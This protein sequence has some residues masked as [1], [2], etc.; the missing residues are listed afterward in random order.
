MMATL[1]KDKKI[2]ERIQKKVKLAMKKL[3]TQAGAMSSDP[4]SEHRIFFVA[5][6]NAHASKF[7][8]TGLNLHVLNTV[9]EAKR[10]VS[11]A[12]MGFSE[13]YYSLYKNYFESKAT[14][15][16]TIKTAYYALRGLKSQA[17]QV[18]L[19]DTWKSYLIVDGT[20]NTITYDVINPMG[21]PGKV[22]SLKKATVMQINKQTTSDITGKVK[23]EGENKVTVEFTKAEVVDLEWTSHLIAFEFEG[24]S[25]GQVLINKT[26]EVKAKI[27]EELG[28]SVS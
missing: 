18:F 23:V 21:G 26:F 9:I 22:K 1:Q 13:E 17:D 15:A 28:V 20:A 11:L 8:L 4:Y 10:G 6:K 3:I 7:D 5:P 27:V 19:K 12:D 25:G 14:S 24:A 16:H 2:G